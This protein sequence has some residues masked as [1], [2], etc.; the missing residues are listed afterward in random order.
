MRD[1]L[2]GQGGV[3]VALPVAAVVEQHV[4]LAGL[5][6]L[7]RRGSLA[8]HGDAWQVASASE[9]ER[10]ICGVPTGEIARGPVRIVLEGGH[11]IVERWEMNSRQAKGRLNIHTNVSSAIE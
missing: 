3:R 1:G 4:L 5:T 10:R 9:V 2:P 8:R 11:A 6:L 7:P